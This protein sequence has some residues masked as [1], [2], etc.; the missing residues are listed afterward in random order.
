[1]QAIHLI[2]NQLGHSYNSGEKQEEWS[3]I[4]KLPYFAHFSLAYFVNIGFLKG[5]GG[6]GFKYIN[7]QKAHMR[8]ERTLFACTITC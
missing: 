3:S 4:P 6:P 2:F 8:N 7:F 1:M 5:M